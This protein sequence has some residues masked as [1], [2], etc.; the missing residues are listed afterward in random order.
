MTQWLQSQQLS[1]TGSGALFWHEGMLAEQSTPVSPIKKNRKIIDLLHYH[2]CDSP[3]STKAGILKCLLNLQIQ[4][5]SARIA[6]FL[7]DKPTVSTEI[8]ENNGI[9]VTD[10]NYFT[11]NI[12]K[13]AAT[14]G[15]SYW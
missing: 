6:V 14:F 1:I 12:Q 15:S 9:L 10:V 5:I 7:T 13:I 11:E 8:F 2:N 4:H 3:S